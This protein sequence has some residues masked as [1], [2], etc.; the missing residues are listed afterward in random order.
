MISE[1]ARRGKG[2]GESRRDREEGLWRGSREVKVAM[3][4]GKR[5]G[6]EKRKRRQETGRRRR[7]GD[8]DGEAALRTCGVTSSSP[9]PLKTSAA[10]RISEVENNVSLG[11]SQ[12]PVSA[13]PGC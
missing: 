6:N 2:R 5:G 10:L 13:Q 7:G 11:F 8:P 12:T 3:R 1:L 9:A 4:N